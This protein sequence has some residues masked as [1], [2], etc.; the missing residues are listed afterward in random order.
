MP[1]DLK[2]GR[3]VIVGASLAG[4]RAAEALREEGFTGSLTVVGDEPH[5]P[6][7]RPPLSK[8]VLLGQATADTT[9]LP[10]RMDPDAEWRLGVRATGVDLLAKRVLLEDGEPLPYDRLLITTGTRARPWPDPDE[11]ALEG[12]FTLRTCEDGAGLAERLAAKPE[13]V[14]VIGA[15]FT[16]SE[17][18]SACRELGVEVTVAE[19]GPAPLVGALGGTLSKLA[20]VMQ[21]NHGVDLRTGVTVTALHGN[22]SFTG[23]ELSDGSRVDADVCVVALGAIR[24]V[25]WLADSGLA[26]GPRGIACDAGCRAFNMYGIVTDDVFV[27]GDVSRF[28]HPL[29]GYQMLSLEHWG[30]AVE[31]AEVAAHN[32][33]NPGPLQRP[34][35]SIPTFW[36]T[37]FGLNIKSV[38]VPTFSDHIVI[39]QGSLEA[40]RLA[41]VY[42]YQGRVTAA[43]TVDMAKALDYYR[44]LIETA[45]PFPPPPGAQDRPIAADI[46]IPSEV[47][48]PS[49]LSHGPTVALTG[50]LPDR[51]LTVV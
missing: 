17:I 11:A 50:H 29:F 35:L 2:D 23:A 21:R 12:V 33:V 4:L 49:V 27:A 24:N 28:P 45:A 40:R 43:V 39:A 19:R 41:M 22:G 38:G 25:E 44:H 32:M 1:G 3:I 13:R 20:A 37:Q 16:G 8:Q 14:L 30:N 46:T 47:P 6:Y 5:A 15:G 26:A 48:D 42:G 34:H 36:S 18:A 10:M 31:Q 51:R 9:E 7:D